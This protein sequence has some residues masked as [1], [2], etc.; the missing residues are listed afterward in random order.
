MSLA[1]IRKETAERMAKAATPLATCACGAEIPA[2]KFGSYGGRCFEC[3]KAYCNAAPPQPPERS[4][5][6][7]E[8]RAQI[9]AAGYGGNLPP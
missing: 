6:A 9:E 1:D 2:D 5:A 3:F 7:R 4:R 8:L